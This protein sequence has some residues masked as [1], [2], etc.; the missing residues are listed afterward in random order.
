M[1][2]ARIRTVSLLALGLLLLALA[3]GCGGSTGVAASSYKDPFPLPRD[4]MQ[5]VAKEV[6]RHGGRFVI[7]QTSA[8]KSFNAIMANETSSTDLTQLLF[9]GLSEYDNGR[10]VE[11]PMV[12]KS[13][14]LSEDGRRWTYH[15]RRGAAFSDGHPITSADV[16]FS[17]EVTYDETLHPSMQELIK[18][19][20]KPFQISAPDSYTVVF[21]I[22]EPYVLMNAVVG[23]VRIMPKHILEPAFRGGN[24]A[25]AYN[26]N[27]APES[28]VTSGAWKLK[29]FVPGEKTVLTRNPYWFGVD[30][31]GQRLPYLD[32]LTFVI[33]PDQNTAFLKFQ[34]GDLDALDNVKPEDYKTYEDMQKSHDFTLHEIGP[35]L[36]TNF[37][38]FNLNRVHEPKPGRK[39]GSTYLDATK[40]AWFSDVR[41]RRAVSMGIDREAMIRGVF[42]GDAV[43]NWATYTAGNKLWYDPTITGADY[44]PEGAKRLLAEAGFKD[45]DGDGVLEDAKGHTVSFTIKTN[46]D[47]VTRV[48]MANFIKDDLAKIGIKCIPTPVDFNT[49]ITNLRQDFQYEALL[50]G[51]SSAVP[52]DPGMGQN[53]FRS[54][55]LTHYWNIKQPRPET[56]QEVEIDRLIGENVGTFD[57]AIRKATLHQIF[58]IWNR[59]VY[60]VWL[61]TV[62]MKLPVSNRFGN[63]EPVPIPHRILWNIDRV[64][65]KSPGRPA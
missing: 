6:G 19:N 26:S 61:P 32:E 43:K 41:F 18:V 33:V 23:S 57:M 31:K 30:S 45:R 25:A 16:L 60:T 39:L 55:G 17:F 29:S 1:I 8:P 58:E 53:V 62:I 14:D 59:E 47:N 20:G 40:Y 13:W 46:G 51:L 3:T 22:A 50:L 63:T 35:S 49:L 4:T 5:F 64:F 34:A 11:I 27:T 56:P 10:Q 2:I 9:V 28:L 7:G 15:M 38:W 65:V 21:D 42:F 12:A 52:P 37:F 36:N 44:D 48:Q 54:S 24:F